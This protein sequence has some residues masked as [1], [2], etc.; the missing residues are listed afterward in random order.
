MLST[1]TRKHLATRLTEVGARNSRPDLARIQEIHDRAAEMGARCGERRTEAD[2]G[3]VDTVGMVAL[4]VPPAVAQ[5]LAVPGGVAA[6]EMHLTL[7]FLGE[8]AQIRNP[9]MI[10]AQVAEIALGRPPL[11]GTINGVGRFLQT[12]KDGEHAI[13]ASPDLKAL[14]E[15]RQSVIERLRGHCQM[16]SDHG[17]VPHITLTYVGEDDPTPPDLVQPTPVVFDTISVVLAGQRTDYKLRGRAYE[18]IEGRYAHIDLTPP[19]AVQQ[20]AMRGLLQMH[21]T[22]GATLEATSRAPAIAAGK[23][24]SLS[25]IRAMTQARSLPADRLLLG[26]EPGQEWARETLQRMEAANSKAEAVLRGLK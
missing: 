10:R 18:A 11:R 3:D 25:C 8:V 7:A 6:T 4:F 19:K 20:T 26:G 12:H 13:Y 5:K 23:P 21:K 17:F 22:G 16:P 9:D 2:Q 1:R 24:L 14:P 15:F